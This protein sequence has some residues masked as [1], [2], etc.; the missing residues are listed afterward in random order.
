MCTTSACLVFMQ[1][2]KEVAEHQQ[3]QQEQTSDAVTTA[4]RA[5]GMSRDS[6]AELAT[7]AAD[8]ATG[9][10]RQEMTLR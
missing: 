10:S 9:M 3:Q 8:K 6:L 7:R 1:A 5:A 2:V 4:A